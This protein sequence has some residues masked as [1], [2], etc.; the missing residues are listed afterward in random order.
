MPCPY[1]SDTESRNTMSDSNNKK[2]AP[3]PETAAPKT[4]PKTAL[5]PIYLALLVGGMILI[6]HALQALYMWKVSARLG[7]AFLATALILGSTKNIRLAIIALIILWSGVAVTF[8][9]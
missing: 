2:H 1:S 3:S 4:K 6:G 9:Y 7:A 8:L 5:T